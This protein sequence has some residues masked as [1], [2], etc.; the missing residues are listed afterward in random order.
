MRRYEQQ[1]YV[2]LLFWLFFIAISFRLLIKFVGF[3]VDVPYLDP[4]MNFLMAI[5]GAICKGFAGF[6]GGW[7]NGEL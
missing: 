2:R 5:L 4:T 6:L 1:F 7:G 3:Q